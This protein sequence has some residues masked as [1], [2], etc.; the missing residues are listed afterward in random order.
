MGATGT[1]D[2]AIFKKHVHDPK[3]KT[4]N[5]SR[6]QDMNRK[7]E[8]PILSAELNVKMEMQSGQH[9]IK[10]LQELR[11]DSKHHWWKVT[12]Y[13]ERKAL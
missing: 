8:F 1:M 11:S 9:R 6:I 12:V 10:I 5:F 7:A 2:A 4:L 13:N 3:N